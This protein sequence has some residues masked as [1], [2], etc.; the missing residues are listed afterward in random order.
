MNVA[1]S[2][3]GIAG[4][5]AALFLA[6]AGHDV[7]LIERAASPEPTG[8][9][10]LLQP[11]GLLVLE[12]LGL[13]AAALRQGQPVRRLHGLTLGGR[14]VMD[15]DYADWAAGWF[16]LGM[17]RGAL[18]R[19]LHGALADAN[20]RVEAGITIAA[21]RE[22]G[23]RCELLDDQGSARG[24]FDLV[25]AA[26]GARST[27]R[28]RHFHDAGCEYPWGALWANLR[29]PA[30]WADQVLQQRYLGARQMM[31]VLPVGRDARGDGPWATLFWSEPCARMDVVRA[32]PAAWRA[33]ANALWPEAAP[34]VEQVRDSSQLL[35]A[36]YRD[37]RP[38]SWIHG[39]LVLIG[40]AAHGTSPQLGQGATLGLLDALSLST[41][42]ADC[43]NV[44]TALGRHAASRAAHVCYYQWASRMLTPFFQ[45]DSR[46]LALLRDAVF[47]LAGKLPVVGAEYRATLVGA[48]SGILIG[49]LEKSL[50]CPTHF[51][52]LS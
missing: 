45:S 41:A 49:R 3:C 17:H 38:A 8:S 29:L 12:R 36:R 15:I 9:G 18:W 32:D 34:L 11:P 37:V 27:L 47:G 46:A 23:D 4:M 51:D 2:G 25:I 50:C 33:A 10:L 21:V 7:T 13:L 30:G 40:D 14:C 16:G 44:A 5:A 24:A 43:A 6:R 39:R 28:Q 48:K 1:I 19:V 42:L 31:G 20:I 35:L 26:D 52:P 22:V